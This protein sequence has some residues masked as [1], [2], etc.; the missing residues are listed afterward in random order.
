MA[1]ERLFEHGHELDIA[2]EFPAIFFSNIGGFIS[3]HAA[4]QH[5]RFQMRAARFY[6]F[7]SRSLANNLSQAYHVWSTGPLVGCLQFL[8]VHCLSRRPKG[9]SIPAARLAPCSGCG[10]AAT[11][12]IAVRKL[13]SHARKYNSCVCLILLLLTEMLD[14]PLPARKRQTAC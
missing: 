6:T 10:R 14:D 5:K 2:V 11:A 1:S 9:W 13:G 4:R 7:A 3:R 12:H 8:Q